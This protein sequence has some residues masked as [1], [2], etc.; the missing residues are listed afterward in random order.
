MLDDKEAVQNAEQECRHSEEVERNDGFSV[1]AKK[2]QEALS[3]EKQLAQIWTLPF[4]EVG[5]GS[6]CA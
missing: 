4:D 3:S 6:S 5:G 2:C 1:V